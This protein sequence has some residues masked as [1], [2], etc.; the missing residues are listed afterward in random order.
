MWKV[1]FTLGVIFIPLWTKLRAKQATGNSSLHE[2]ISF[3]LKRLPVTS[4]MKH[5]W[6]AREAAQTWS[7]P[8]NVHQEITV[9]ASSKDPMLG[10]SRFV[11]IYSSS[12]TTVSC[13]E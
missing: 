1:H 6:F 9:N 12:R 5:A 7:Q 13:T 3:S 11:A 4:K 8:K 2:D 10:I